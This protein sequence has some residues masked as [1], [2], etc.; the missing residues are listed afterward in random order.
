[1]L[2]G[3]SHSNGRQRRNFLPHHPVNADLRLRRDE[4]NDMTQRHAVNYRRRRAGFRL[5][6]NIDE[7]SRIGL[8]EVLAIFCEGGKSRDRKEQKEDADFQ[9]KPAV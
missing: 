2:Q 7:M 3:N 9:T 8:C 6:G 5:A 4:A 1:M